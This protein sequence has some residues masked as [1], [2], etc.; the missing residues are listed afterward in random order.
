MGV[1]YPVAGK[2]GTT[3]N[4]RDAWFVGYTP[5]V[6]ALVWVGF[7]DGTSI[8]ATGSAAALPVWAELVKAIPRF[9]SGNGFTMPAGVVRRHVCAGSGQLAI[10]GICPETVEEI[11][12]ADNVPTHTCRVHR[13]V[14]PITRK[15]ATHED[16]NSNF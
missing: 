11:F 15:V 1:T 6:L 13:R 9:I 7:D 2:T 5:D 14:S 8:Q 16:P 4:F 10:P 12:L 3:N